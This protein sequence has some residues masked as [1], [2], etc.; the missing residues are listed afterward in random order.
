MFARVIGVPKYLKD[1]G[2]LLYLYNFLQL[3]KRGWIKLL[4]DLC[5]LSW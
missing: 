5:P 1:E 2:A 4:Q 3:N